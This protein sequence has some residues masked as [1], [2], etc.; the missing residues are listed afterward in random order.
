MV[1]ASSA[2]PLDPAWVSTPAAKSTMSGALIAQANLSGPSGGKD[3]LVS[4]TI[5]FEKVQHEI[6]KR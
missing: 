1:G 5:S 3:G 2:R 6:V 4:A